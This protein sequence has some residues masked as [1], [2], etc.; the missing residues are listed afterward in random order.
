[1]LKAIGKLI[2]LVILG[3][4]TLVVGNLNAFADA[5]DPYLS[6]F[7]GNIGSVEAAVNTYGDGSSG[8]YRISSGKVERWIRSDSKGFLVALRF[9]AT[10]TPSVKVYYSSE[11]GSYDIKTYSLFTASGREKKVINSDG[12]R[13]QKS[14]GQYIYAPNNSLYGVSNK[15]KVKNIGNSTKVAISTWNGGDSS[16]YNLSRGETETWSR[17]SDSRGYLMNV[18]GA[19]YFIKSGE[20][21]IVNGSNVYINNKLAMR[22]DLL[23]K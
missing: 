18:N 13:Y 17:N 22:C 15:I 11:R 14:N 4:G 16:Y 20:S 12:N 7:N 19:K 8:Y 9:A 2:T 1:M 3:V 23:D 10:P 5:V 21:A 6:V